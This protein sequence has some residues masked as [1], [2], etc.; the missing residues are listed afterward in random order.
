MKYFKFDSANLQAKARLSPMNVTEVKYYGWRITMFDEFSNVVS[1]KEVAEDATASKPIVLYFVCI[2]V[3]NTIF[4]DSIYS[5][6]V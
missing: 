6:L 1:I 3:G 2:V 5:W 4:I